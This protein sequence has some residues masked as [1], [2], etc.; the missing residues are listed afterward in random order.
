MDNGETIPGLN[1]DWSLGG[2]K[3]MEWIA[4]FCS[5]MIASELL[6]GG[7]SGRAM[8][9][10]LMIWLMTTFSLAGL[11]KKFPDEE[12][13]MRNAV[14]T[15]CGI[16]PPGIPAPAQLQPYWSGCPVRDLKEECD[17]KILGIWDVIEELSEE[18]KE[19]E[20]DA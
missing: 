12:R 2:A 9:Q 20:E 8:P 1:E 16:H 10:L 18:E 6:Y 3:M 5:F 15:A 11:R 4:G 7:P 13:G 17:L 14:M 19:G